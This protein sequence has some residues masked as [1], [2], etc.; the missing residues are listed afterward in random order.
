MEPITLV[1]LHGR[2]NSRWTLLSWSGC[3]LLTL[4]TTSSTT[5]L[6][7]QDVEWQLTS[8]FII[9]PMGFSSTTT[10]LKR[11]PC[12]QSNVPGFKCGSGSTWNCLQTWLWKLITQ[13]CLPS[14]CSDGN[15]NPNHNPQWILVKWMQIV[16]KITQCVFCKLCDDIF[17]DS[18]FTSYAFI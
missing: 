13:N 11:R 9:K 14:D 6:T 1:S 17:K 8:R 4:S 12:Q 15:V 10:T 2:L 16:N 7:S 18:S 3:G 5:H